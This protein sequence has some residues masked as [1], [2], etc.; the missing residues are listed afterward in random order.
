M[1]IF[2][3]EDQTVA[4]VCESAM[5]AFKACESKTKSQWESC[6]DG[7]CIA[8]ATQMESEGLITTANEI[9]DMIGKSKRYK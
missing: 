8:I 2:A 5:T 9:R 4:K 7:A 1:S 3:A 6:W